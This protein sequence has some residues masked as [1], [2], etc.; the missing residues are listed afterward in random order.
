MEKKNLINKKHYFKNH[1]TFIE[2]LELSINISLLCFNNYNE[3][4]TS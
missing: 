3:M 1:A 4:I 2:N